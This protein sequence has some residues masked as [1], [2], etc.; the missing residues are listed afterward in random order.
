M[1]RKYISETVQTLDAVESVKNET[2]PPIDVYDAVAWMVITPLSEVSIAKGSMPV[3]IPDFT[4]GQWI[5]PYTGE[6]HKYSLDVICEDKETKFIK[7][8]AW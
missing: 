8:F 1:Y 7:C 6:Q 3:G 4:Y 2:K 5:E